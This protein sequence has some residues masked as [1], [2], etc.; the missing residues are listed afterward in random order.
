MR[1]TIMTISDRDRISFDPKNE[2]M[3]VDFTGRN[4]TTMAD[5]HAFYDMTEEMIRAQE[6][7]KW[8]FLV[9]LNDTKIQPEAWVTY[10]KRGRLLNE[11][12]SLGSVRFDASDAT[13][14]EIA[15][16]A[17]SEEFDANLFEDREG[18]IKR[19]AYLRSIAPKR[20]PMKKRPKSEWG[21]E[22]FARRTTIHDQLGIMEAD[23]SD[24]TFATLGDVH[25]FY[26]HLDDRMRVTGKKWFFLVNYMNTK[27][28]PEVW[29]AFANRGKKLNMDFSL[30]S[31]RYDASEDTAKE[32][33]RR[34]N[35]EEFDPNLFAVR[36]DALARIAELRAKL[37]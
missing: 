17:N 33:A 5:V 2:T 34:A 13:K 6:G 7:D 24:F 25:D 18:A 1:L 29:G 10:G 32:I 31:V 12:F 22:E 20:F 28:M 27:I 36:D 14:R 19:I 3:E 21:V 37:G 35:T 8:Y 26:D 30:G 4:F 16:R 15:A 11:A 23:F 9:N